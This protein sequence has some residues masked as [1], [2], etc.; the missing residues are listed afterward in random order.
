MEHGSAA[1]FSEPQ[2]KTR[3]QYIS[4][5]LAG[6][7]EELH[8]YLKTVEDPGERYKSHPSPYE[9]RKYV[10]LLHSRNFLPPFTPL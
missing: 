6:I 7:F 4:V 1:K 8:F 10:L 3:F 5:S 9:I 2:A